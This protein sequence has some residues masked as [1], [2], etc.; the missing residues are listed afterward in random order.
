M[1]VDIDRELC[2][3]HGQCGESAP[4]I[5]EVRDD[6]LAYLLVDAIPAD[7]EPNVRDAASRCPVDA[8]R[9]TD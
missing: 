9:L 6:G 8:I 1:N 2:Q 3:G 7:Q 5:F 4:K